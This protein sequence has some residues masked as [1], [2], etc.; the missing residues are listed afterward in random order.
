M[1]PMLYKRQLG[2]ISDTNLKQKASNVRYKKLIPEMLSQ[3]YITSMDM[4]LS[5]NRYL[6]SSTSDGKLYL[7]DIVTNNCLDHESQPPIFQSQRS[8]ETVKFMWD[9]ESFSSSGWDKTLRIFD[10]ENLKV[11]ASHK[12]NHEISKHELNQRKCLC[13][14]TGKKSCLLFD[15]KSQT[16]VMEIFQQDAQVTNLQWNEQNP[17]LLLIASENGLFLWDVR[18]PKKYLVKFK[19][20][21][22]AI[23]NQ[24]SIFVG[25]LFTKDF[26][27]VISFGT[28]GICFW[29]LHGELKADL[30]YYSESRFT[31]S[32][33]M[34]LPSYPCK[35]ELVFVPHKNNVLMVTLP[36]LEPFHCYKDSF[37]NITWIYNLPNSYNVITGS[38][39]SETIIWKP[40]VKAKKWI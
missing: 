12:F 27:N 36:H 32:L 11:I 15:L 23:L 24:S 17:N 29:D 13:S 28:N 35:P 22:E 1:I 8:I 4:E 30:H 6:L 5:C 39:C 26:S 33:Q 25:C 2:L 16:V 9:F 34:C 14:V 31:R 38:H 37:K 10:V 21:E 40:K 18:K 3:S 20:P 7:D 19:H